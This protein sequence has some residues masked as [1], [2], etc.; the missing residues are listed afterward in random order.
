[1]GRLTPIDHG[2]CLPPISSLGEAEFGWLHWRQAKQPFSEAT[3]QW[4]AGLS[5]EDDAAIL[6]QLGLP[7]ESIMTSK[8]CTA[9]L[10]RCVAAGLTLHEIGTMFV[11]EGLGQEPSVLELAVREAFEASHNDV[12]QGVVTKFDKILTNA[13]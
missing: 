3:K 6:R 10:K 8:V 4:V 1:M 2:L 11:R 13:Q 5:V 9:V 7:E 12:V